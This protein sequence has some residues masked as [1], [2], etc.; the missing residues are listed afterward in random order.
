MLKLKKVDSLALLL[1]ALLWTLPFA[2]IAEDSYFFRIDTELDVPLDTTGGVTVR[3]K[4]NGTGEGSITDGTASESV[5]LLD[6]IVKVASLS[7]ENASDRAGCDAGEAI[8]ATA[9]FNGWVSRTWTDTVSTVGS[10]ITFTTRASLDYTILV[11]GVADELGNALTLNGTTA[12]ATYSGTVASQSYSGGKRY[13]AGSTSGGTVKGGADGYV[14][15]TSS[16]VTISSSASQS[17]DFGTSDNSSLNESGLLFGVK[18]TLNGTTRFNT[19]SN[20]ITGATVKAGNSA[21]TSCTDNSDGK[22]YCAIPL[23]HTGT[24]AEATNIPQGMDNASCT[25]TDRSAGSDAQSTCT[26]SASERG[27]VGGGGGGTTTVTS[28]SP[29]PVTSTTP[30]PT[31]APTVTPLLPSPTPL[32]PSSPTPTRVKPTIYGLKE[33]DIVAALSSSDPDVYIVNAHGFKRLFLNPVIF[34]FYGHLGFNKVKPVAV[35]TRD[36]FEVSG[37]FRNCEINDKKVY[38]VEVTGEDVGMLHHV[39]LTG[40]E[41]VAQDSEFFKK[42]FCINTN[43]FNWYTANGKKFGTPYSAL[44]QLPKY[45]RK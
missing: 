11:N 31:P 22:Y 4:C 1:A 40:D 15:R 23:A 20:N 29:S 2:A 25:Y 37:L 7:A 38:G 44:N 34:G 28:P 36:A 5:N 18:V 17:V 13:I 35:V 42:V 12:S 30:S 27:A 39:N 6:G 41:A 3:W 26:I 33:G 16:T 8:T 10:N 14:N 45:Q 21:G 32:A 9:S 43:E 24:S 19:A